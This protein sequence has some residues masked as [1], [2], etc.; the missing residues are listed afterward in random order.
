MFRF[1]PMSFVVPSLCC[2]LASA[3]CNESPVETQDGP[4]ADTSGP[5]LD[6]VELTGVATGLTLPV[7][8]TAPDG[9]PR[10]F[11]VEKVGR[12]RIV[13]NGQL[14]GTPFLDVSSLVSNGGEQG[15][16]SMAF[17]PEYATNGH[18]YVYYTDDSGDTQV[19]RYSVSG[20]ANV[21]DPASAKVIFSLQQPYGNHNGGLITFGPDGMLYIGLGDGG[22]GGDPQGHGQNLGTLLGSLLRIDVD[23]GDP[24]AIP[25]DNPFVNDA[26]ALD[27]IWAYG[28]RNPWRYSFDPEQGA[29]YIADVGQSSREE[30]N[31]QSDLVG[32]VN[33]GWNVMEGT[34]CFNAASC[35]QSGLHQPILE[36]AT[37]SDGCAVV[38]GFMYRGDAINGLDGT[39][40]YS[41]NCAGWI[42]SFDLE[43]GQAARLLQWDLG[44]IGNV[45]SFGQDSD[46]ELY[47]LSANGNVYKFVPDR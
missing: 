18:F 28:L 17:H 13:S 40:F 22:D 41:D 23:T 27:E 20:N 44:N 21:A 24:Y 4:P 9:D 31:V 33:Y 37:G 6:D 34:G 14:L 45:L 30:I 38:G 2:V 1:G 32:G 7:H 47:V 3:A 15:L 19:V 42:R 43:F 36:Y 25:A 39:Y 12:V 10:L 26:G 8:L 46:G 35:D 16:L 29:I 11:V 5:T